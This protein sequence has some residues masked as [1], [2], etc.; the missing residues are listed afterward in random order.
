MRGLETISRNAFRSA[1]L[2]FIVAVICVGLFQWVS[3]VQKERADA[4]INLLV[5]QLTSGNRAPATYDGADERNVGIVE[6][7]P[8]D[9]DQSKQIPVD[10]A[11]AQLSSMG[12]EAWLPLIEQFENQAYCKTKEVADFEYNF[13][14]AQMSQW[15]LKNTIEQYHD[16]LGGGGDTHLDTGSYA[17][18]HLPDKTTALEWQ[19]QHHT[20]QLW[21]V[22]VEAIEWL[23]RNQ[24]VAD[25]IDDPD[26][27]RNRCKEIQARKAPVFGKS[28]GDL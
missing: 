25:E 24:D 7:F 2:A 6:S 28:V 4:K 27:L 5:Q 26:A 14:V 17:R 11:I 3:A 19:R 15:I 16:C 10:A 22:Q 21:E 12:K 13:S 8:S 9:Y 18:N 20:L 23:L 1:V